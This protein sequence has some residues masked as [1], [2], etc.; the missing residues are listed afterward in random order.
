VL[1]LLFKEWCPPLGY[2]YCNFSSNFTYAGVRLITPS[3]TL[4][5]WIGFSV[6][7]AYYDY[8]ISIYEWACNINTHVGIAKTKLSYK[9]YPNPSNGM[10][11][12]ELGQMK[13]E[14]KLELF[15]INGESIFR[16]NYPGLSKEPIVNFGCAYL[17]PGVYILRIINEDKT[18]YEKILILN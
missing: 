6:T 11:K 3:D 12:M 1:F 5:G 18:R 2:N 14:T 16:Y 4:H 10:F 13:S 9:I 8:H 17:K 15:N 7:P